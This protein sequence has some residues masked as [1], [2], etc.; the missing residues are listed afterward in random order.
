[1]KAEI[2]NYGVIV[3]SLSVPDRNGKYDDIVLGFETLDGYIKNLVLKNKHQ[4]GY[5]VGVHPKN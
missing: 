4:G 2:T 3:V 5:H 1:M